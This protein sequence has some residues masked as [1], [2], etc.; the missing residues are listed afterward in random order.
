[1][2]P[3]AR[4]E[5]TRAGDRYFEQRSGVE[6]EFLLEVSR[7]LDLIAETPQGWQRLEEFAATWDVRR[8][9]LPRFPYSIIYEASEDGVLVIAVAH[10]SRDPSY[11]KRRMPRKQ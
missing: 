8:F 10:V 4:A 1:M 9:V 7:A 5:L 6:L 2:A 11:W 3:A